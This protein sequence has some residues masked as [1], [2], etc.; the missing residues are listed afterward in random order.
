[1]KTYDAEE[2]KTLDSLFDLTEEQQKTLD[3][4]KDPDEP[5]NSRFT[6]DENFQKRVLGSML[7]DINYLSQAR[8][9]VSPTYFSDEATCSY[10]CDCF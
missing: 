6:W 7:A 1:M 2:I 4:L 8:A 9:I 5:Q 3:S 10:V